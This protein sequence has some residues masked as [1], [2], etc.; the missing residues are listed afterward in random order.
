MVLF[1][2]FNFLLFISYAL[3][4]PIR[5]VIYPLPYTWFNLQPSEAQ[6]FG[7][8]KASHFLV[9][10]DQ[11]TCEPRCPLQPFCNHEEAD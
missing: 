5:I 6:G 3:P 4:Q 2:F 1:I 8:R 7:E 9:G 10:C 11:G